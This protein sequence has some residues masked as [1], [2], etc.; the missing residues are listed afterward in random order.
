MPVPTFDGVPI[1]GEAVRANPRAGGAEWQRSGFP[2]IHGTEDLFMGDRGATIELTFELAG[3]TVNDLA[4][5]RNYF[6]FLQSRGVTATFRDTLGTDWPLC[7]VVEF[8]PADI[9]GEW[10]GGWS[11]KFTAT[12]VCQETPDFGF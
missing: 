9:P 1:F 3:A 6:Y 2:G 5:A 11:Q 8:G 4:A 12:L 10:G 7:K